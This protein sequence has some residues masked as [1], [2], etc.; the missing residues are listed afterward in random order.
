[1]GV[2]GDDHGLAADAGGLPA[3]LLQDPDMAG[4]DA[5]KSP[6]GNN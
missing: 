3:E 1:M 5:V 6:D 4:M 2:K